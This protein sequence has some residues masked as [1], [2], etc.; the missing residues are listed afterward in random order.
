V[1]AVGDRALRR[2]CAAVV[3]TALALGG[4]ANA[5]VPD[6]FGASGDQI[7]TGGGGVAHVDDGAATTLNPA[8]LSQIRRPSFKIGALWAHQT[9]AAP[10]PLWW[11]TNRD[12][13]VDE[14]DPNLQL[15]DGVDDVSG[16]Q[17]SVGRQVG[18][19]FGI[20]I[21]AYVP[22]Q[23]LYRLKTFEP[24]LPTYIMYDNRQ[25]R[26]DFSA[27]VGGEVLPGVSIGAAVNI[28]PRVK[29]SV[30]MTADIQVSGDS[31][32]ADL[33][34]AVQKLVVDVQEVKLDLVPGIAPVFGLQLDLGRWH[35]ALRGLRIGAS[36]RGSVGVP[37]EGRLDIQANV[38]AADI[39]SLNP[40]VL[41][42][43]I[44]AR[45]FLFDH[46]LPM[47]VDA[48]LSYEFGPGFWA[49]GD[50]RWTD[51]H[52]M[53]LSVAQ[54]QDT[55]LTTPLFD[56]GDRVRDGNAYSVVLR[57]V[58]SGRVGGG[59]RFPRFELDSRARY[60]EVGMQVGAG[61]EPT[62]LVSQGANSAFLDADRWWLSGGL[63]GETW[64]PFRLVNGP[65]RMGVFFQYHRLVTAT[66]NHVSDTPKAG[67]SANGAPML[68]DGSILL[69]GG[70]F[71]FEY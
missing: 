30:G 19:R 1:S 17:L 21:S 57:N 54:L 71:G 47:K 5:T 34:D 66:L 52:K 29:F 69:I 7:A 61:Y 9:F 35:K 12:G 24:S 39:G 22:L 11:D 70:Q 42:G 8:G 38:S 48:G 37:I 59:I 20:G 63:S 45:L 44:D 50:V 51:W 49:Y 10:P 23:R 68:A 2:G 62:P 55:T 4:P 28:V 46:Y 67:F 25:Q 16:F 14:G 13:V 15:G 64:D 40:F 3:G 65:I 56:L 36:W 26:Y 33:G 41:A 31:D 6:D 43:V 27:G 58:T 60:L 32:T 53:T 18:S